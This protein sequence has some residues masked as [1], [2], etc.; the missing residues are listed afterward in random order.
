MASPMLR[1]LRMLPARLANRVGGLRDERGSIL[2][3]ALASMVLLAVLTLAVLQEVDG[4]TASSG[5]NKARTVAAQLAEQDQER[6]R[7]MRFIDLSNYRYSRAVP[8]DGVGY[9]VDSRTD[10]I[11]D[12]TGA[13]ESCT[14][15]TTQ[16]SYLRIRS[17]VTSNI[18]GTQ[19]RPVVIDS[20]LAPQVDTFGPDE[21]TLAV[22][23][24]DRDAQ[25][26]VGKNV[27]ITGQS[28][29]LSDVTNSVGCAIF[30]YIPKGDYTVSL[31]APGWVTDKPIPTGKVIAG[32]VNVLSINYDQAA[33]VTA[34][35]KTKLPADTAA[36]TPVVGWKLNADNA[37]FGG[38][39]ATTAATPT[40]PAAQITAPDLFPFKTN[41][42]FYSGDCQGPAPEEFNDPTKKTPAYYATHPGLQAL[43]PG[44]NVALDVVQPAVTLKVLNNGAPATN[45]TLVVKSTSSQCT[46][47][48][49][50]VVGTDGLIRKPATATASYDPSLPFGRYTIAV[51]VP[52]RGTK[53][54]TVDNW[55][56]AGAICTVMD[57]SA[58]GPSGGAT[59][60]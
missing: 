22:K 29:T 45:A 39:P 28:R 21:G 2:L 13:T 40:A 41:Y 51:T 38:I 33:T 42:S 36:T 53:T 16:S 44:D 34:S 58:G 6:M 7:G 52:S 37:G 46:A 14:N 24:L 43:N 19:T 4:A 56:A 57:V 9:T 30:A 10:W 26:L 3:E 17:T 11:R 49:P 50:M 20:L 1:P 55:N 27:T 48:F 12:A 8:V 23:L 54:V 18:V 59:C 35:F 25:P 31:P 47:A 32:Q 5:R 15:D 60:P